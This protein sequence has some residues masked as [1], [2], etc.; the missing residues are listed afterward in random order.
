MRQ[1]FIF[2]ALYLLAGVV[3]VLLV[4]EDPVT[5]LTFVMIKSVSLAKSLLVY[6][7]YLGVFLLIGLFLT[8]HLGLKNRIA[9]T[10]YAFFGCMMFSAAFSLVKTTIPHVVPFYADEMFAN[11][12]A[13]I[14]LGTQPWVWA[15]GLADYIPANAIVILYFGIWTLPAIFLPVIIA[16]TDTDAARMRRFLIL[17]VLCWVG[18]GN[19]VAT[20]FSSVGPV[21]YDRLLGGERFA[22]LTAALES[23][24]IK[25]S[26]L[27]IVQEGLWTQFIENGQAIGSGISAFPSV[28]VGVATVFAF[29]LAERSRVLIPVSVLFLGAIS[30]ASVY[31]GWH[32]AIDGYVSMVLIAAAWWVLQ[33]R[34]NVAFAQVA[35]A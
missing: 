7:K 31:N 27:G 34:R 25:A 9:P 28:H 35:P 24:G 6:A 12:D 26:K 22:G 13:M 8:R 5:L 17:H 15:H 32:Y 11:L 1:F 4:R 33:R 30:F 2:S 18:L 19:V 3:L 14:H 23:S 21:Y 20:L 10:L 16:I 29:Y